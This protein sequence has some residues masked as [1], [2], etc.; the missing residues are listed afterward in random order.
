M[1]FFEGA[2]KHKQIALLLTMIFV[3]AGL[4][5]IETLLNEDKR[6][7]EVTSFIGTASPRFY[8]T[9][10]PQQPEKNYAQTQ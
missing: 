7:T 10:A 4:Y 2:L 6:I 5:S 8:M 1:K 9:Y 3:V